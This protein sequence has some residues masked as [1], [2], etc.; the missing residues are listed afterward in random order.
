[1]TPNHLHLK[2]QLPSRIFGEIPDV[3]RVVADS[4]NGSFGILC[5]RRDCVAALSPSILMY[6]TEAHGEVFVA[7]DEGILVKAGFEVL[8]SV[9]NAVGGTDLGQLK[10]AIREQFLRMDEQDKVMRN[11]VAKLEVGVLHQLVG[12]LHA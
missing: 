11:A 3:T 10:K 6:A 5:H 7:V 8:V 1:M 4:Q 9:R 12:F 2:I